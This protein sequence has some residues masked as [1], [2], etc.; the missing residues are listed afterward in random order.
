M[1]QEDITSFRKRE[2]PKNIGR[3]VIVGKNL[4]SNRTGSDSW[5]LAMVFLR[6][7]GVV[8]GICVDSYCKRN[9]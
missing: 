3:I 5:V 6:T 7:L 8:M 1:I 2:T 9:S 4:N